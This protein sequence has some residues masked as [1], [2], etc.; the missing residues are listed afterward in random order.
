MRKANVLVIIECALMLGLAVVLSFI[1]VWQM[2]MGGSVTLLSMLPIVFI[3]IKY[4]VKTGLAVG[5]LFAVIQFMAG[6]GTV[7]T[8]GMTPQAVIGSSLL[9][10]FIPYTCLGFAGLLRKKSLLGWSVG[11]AMV[12]IFRF[13]SHFV[14]G[15]II[16]GQWAPEGWGV[17]SYSL[18]YNG[19]IMLPELVFSMIGMVVLF[20][21]PYVRKSF[22]PMDMR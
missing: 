12:M 15:I 7:L 21:I 5:F 10:Y 13:L 1:R 14:S 19:T 4:G 6:I 22:S 16:F 11:V 8:W 9:D 3:S 18:V 20:K 17:V 2:P